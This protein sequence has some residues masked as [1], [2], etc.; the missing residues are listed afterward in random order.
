MESL[1]GKTDTKFRMVSALLVIR[2][3]TH[4]LNKQNDCCHFEIF[5]IFTIDAFFMKLYDFDITGSMS[6]IFVRFH[7]E[8]SILMSHCCCQGNTN[9]Y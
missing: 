7:G 1:E 2:L 9:L 6:N 4:V 8:R 5:T 3:Y